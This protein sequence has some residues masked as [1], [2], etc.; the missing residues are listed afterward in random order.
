MGHENTVLTI[1]CKFILGALMWGLAVELGTGSFILVLG[2]PLFSSLYVLLSC[3]CHHDE[4]ALQSFP[5]HLAI[6]QRMGCFLHL[7]AP[8]KWWDPKNQVWVWYSHACG[9]VAV[10]ILIRNGLLFFLIHHWLLLFYVCRFGWP[11][12]IPTLCYSCIWH[13]KYVILIKLFHL[14][15][16]QLRRHILSEIHKKQ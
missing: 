8:P 4:G 14:I 11:L 6:Q 7:E 10:E 15:P 2:L 3:F 13:L 9:E 5:C 16:S 12:F 1:C